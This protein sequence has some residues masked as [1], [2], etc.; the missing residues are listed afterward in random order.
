VLVEDA[1]DLVVRTADEATPVGSSVLSSVLKS[2]S[3]DSLL[4]AVV[5]AL[6]N[7]ARVVVTAPVSVA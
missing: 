2:S 6:V 1:D 7:R 4:L 5:V 3:A